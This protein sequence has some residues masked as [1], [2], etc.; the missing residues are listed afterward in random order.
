MGFY[1]QERIQIFT[2]YWV[3]NGLWMVKVGLVVGSTVNKNYGTIDLDVFADGSMAN[4]YEWL[5]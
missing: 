2:N 1:R 4:D 5:K 3:E